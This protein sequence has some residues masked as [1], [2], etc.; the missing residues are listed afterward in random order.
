MRFLGL[1]PSYVL[2]SVLHF[3]LLVLALTVAALY[4]IDLQRQHDD[5]ERADSRWVGFFLFFSSSLPF[6]S[7]FERFAVR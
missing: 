2:F 3:A 7:S 5:E 6:I 4:G 1:A